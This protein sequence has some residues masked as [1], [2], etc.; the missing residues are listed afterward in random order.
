MAVALAFGVGGNP[1][2]WFCMSAHEAELSLDA[3]GDPQLICPI[4]GFHHIYEYGPN[5]QVTVTVISGGEPGV[6][7]YGSD[8]RAPRLGVEVK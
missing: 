2:R 1:R 7:H 8:P 5:N 4:C 6:P 3:D